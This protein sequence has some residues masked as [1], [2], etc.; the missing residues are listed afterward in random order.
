[1]FRRKPNGIQRDHVDVHTLMVTDE[2]RK[3]IDDLPYAKKVTV[4]LGALCHDFGKPATTKF[5]RRSLA[6]ARARR[7]GNRADAFFFRYSGDLYFGR[8]R[9]A[10]TDR[11]TRPLS[12]RAG[13][14]LQ[15]A[16]RRRRV[17]PTC[18][19]GRA[20]FIVSRGESRQL[21]QKSRLAA[22]GKMVQGGSARMVYRADAR[23]ECRTRS[24]ETDFDGQTFD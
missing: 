19:K 21:G 17:S 13:N 11:S 16:T 3:L 6:F 15:I 1:M 24:T 18:Q 10:R 7:S 9:R 20:G 23:T 2:A 22:E 14:V 5:F 4:M 12:S 8:F